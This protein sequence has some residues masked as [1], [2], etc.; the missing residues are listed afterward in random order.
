MRLIRDSLH[1][2]I[3]VLLYYIALNLSDKN[4]LQRKDLLEKTLSK[5]V[6]PSTHARFKNGDESSSQQLQIVAN[7]LP[8]RFTCKPSKHNA[9][10][11]KLFHTPRKFNSS[12]LNS[13]LS[14]R[15]GSSSNHHFS[16]AMFHL[17]FAFRG[18]FKDY[19]V[20]FFETFIR[21]IN[22]LM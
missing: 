6:V 11:W 14:N 17:F 2:Y 10:W 4:M 21:I 1:I 3:Y 18:K 7:R 13:Y 16:G 20:Y 15:K 19:L 12:T 5:I 22:Q 9:D 8:L